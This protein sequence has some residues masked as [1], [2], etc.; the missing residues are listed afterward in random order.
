MMQKVKNA[1]LVEKEF[2]NSA[3]HELLTPVTILQTRFENLVASG[4]LPDDAT[5]KIVDSQKH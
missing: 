2:I 5:D 3:S 1:F 4:N